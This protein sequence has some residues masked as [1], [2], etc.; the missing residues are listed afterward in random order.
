MATYG[1]PKLNIDIVYKLLKQYVTITKDDTELTIKNATANEIDI[2]LWLALHQDK[3]SI[4]EGIKYDEVCLKYNICKQSFYNALYSLKDM[5]Y[6]DICSGMGGFWTIHILNNNIHTKHNDNNIRYLNVNKDFLYTNNFKKL[7]ANEKRICLYLLLQPR[8]CNAESLNI[9]AK[10][11]SDKIQISNLTLIYSYL[12]S[13]A[14]FFPFDRLKPDEAARG[15]KIRFKEKNIICTQRVASESFIYLIH[16][17]K[18]KLRKY[19]IPYT[20]SD[21]KDLYTL[22]I[23]YA[24]KGSERLVQVISYTIKSKGIILPKLIN[25]FLSRDI[26]IQEF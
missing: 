15:D 10:T 26:P 16:K 3:H 7:K 12:E 24:E 22:I 2:F 14:K 21:I 11:I 19:S 1:S 9:Y 17:I 6:I 5:G 25:Y 4:V 23:Q 18:Y 13:I 20:L 8:I